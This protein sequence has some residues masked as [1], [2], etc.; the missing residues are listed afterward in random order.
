MN[1][2]S[3]LENNILITDQPKGSYGIF[4]KQKDKIKNKNKSSY[5][6]KMDVCQ[7]LYQHLVCSLHQ[8]LACLIKRCSNHMTSHAS[9]ATVNVC[10]W[11]GMFRPGIPRRWT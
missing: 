10:D 7:V 2:K 5:E 4:L 1:F 8:Y 6:D 3:K 9:M 11:E